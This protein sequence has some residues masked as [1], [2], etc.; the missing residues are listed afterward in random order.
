MANL[1]PSELPKVNSLADDDIFIAEVEPNNLLNLRVV[2]IEKKHLFSGYLNEINNLGRGISVGESISGSIL[3]LKTLFGGAG[4]SITENDNNEALISVSED[5]AHTTASNIGSGL[6]LVSGELNSDLKIKSIEVGNFLS[7]S[8]SS[9]SL[10][11]DFTGQ[12]EATTASNIGGG[13][14]LLSGI[15]DSDIKLKSITG[16]S[17]IAIS[18]SNNTLSIEFTGELS[19]SGPGGAGTQF[20]FFSN[21]ENNLGPTIKTYY[22]TPTSDTYLSGIEVDTAA[23]LKVYLRWDGPGDSY[24]GS[25]FIDGI[26]IPDNQITELGSF[27]RR[28]EGYLDNLSFIGR[29]FI[30]GEANGV[31]SVITLNELGGGPTPTSLTIANISNATPKNGTLLGQTHL[32]GDDSINVYATFD[33]NDVDVIKV[34]NSGISDGISES[35]YSLI[36]TGDGNYTAMIP[37][38]ITNLR[39]GLQGVSVIARNAF[40]TSG[41]A[42][43]SSNQIN[44]DQTYP[45]ISAND[46]TSYNG[47]SDG[48]RNGESTTFINSIASWD[49][50]N[51]D[52][53]LYSGSTNDILISNSGTFE[54]PKTVSYVDGI[55]SDQDNLSIEAVRVNNGAVDTDNVKI[56]I[57]N[58]PQITSIF[59]DAAAT[60]AQSPNVVGASEVKGGDTI[61]A[62][63]DV[64]SNESSANQINLQI[65]NYGLSEG[66]SASNYSSTDLG[67]GVF[68]YTVPIIVTD[69]SS[70]NGTVGIKA[71]PSNSLYNIFGD[72][73]TSDDLVDLNNSYPSV[74]ITSVSYPTNQEAL[75]NSESALVSNSASNFDTI[76][77]S[78]N[79]QLN[80]SDPSV[81]EG[82][83]TVNRLNGGYNISTNNFTITATKNS[84]GAVSSSSTVIKIA[85]DP[86]TFSINGLS[87]PLSSSPAGIS[88]NFNLVSSQL[89]LS[90][91]SLNT[92]STQTIASDLNHTS[93]GTNTNSNSFRITVDDLDTKGT[94]SWQ[95]SGDNLAGITTTTISTNPNYIIQGFSARTITA[96]PTSLGAGL[97]PIGTS[98]S[99]PSNVSMEN[100]SEGGSGPNAGTIY[101][102]E[103][104]PDGT[105]L[106]NSYD[107]DNKF[108]V[109]DSLG[110]TNSNG[111]HIFNLDKLN[112]AANT[113]VNNPAQFA[114]SED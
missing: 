5:L 6:G 1:R 22:N 80:I 46:P 63:I 77:Y 16:G 3:N 94:F 39:D 64:Q 52:T 20:A 59:F 98:V 26:R 65:L 81:Y 60:S 89:M 113:A 12:T 61:N 23:D 92:D 95:V 67:G 68:R 18:E 103:S 114:V 21:A 75:K 53:V 58:P 28:F 19:S 10:F 72:E 9:D 17:N 30:S 79:G 11:I 71:T 13:F 15:T 85:N 31:S 107:L 24:M 105:Q 4:I 57:A 90:S 51:G 40:G 106:D 76:S 108:T 14:G 99:N 2:Q 42:T 97:A 84:N 74:S 29:E 37:I 73:F 8:D 36:D 87:S 69:E 62:Y 104:Y 110:V 54:N 7:I 86:L 101:S 41:S 93:A 70:R 32:K 48:L 112:R 47:R 88:D 111:D 66:Q 44:I 91:P 34:F 78:S 33:T 83:K 96:S 35:S 43:E 49:S 25:G 82:S 55:Y 100:I 50:S 56:K 27:T 38:T 102:Y 45:S 109:C